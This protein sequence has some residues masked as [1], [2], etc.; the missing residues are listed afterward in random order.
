M[1]FLYIQICYSQV[2]ALPLETIHLRKYGKK[3]GGHLNEDGPLSNKS[4]VE[5]KRRRMNKRPE[6][7]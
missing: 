5:R 3:K 7:N 1:L 6:L 2:N 4:F